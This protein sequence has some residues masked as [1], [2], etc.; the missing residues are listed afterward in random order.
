MTTQEMN[1]KARAA[2]FQMQFAVLMLNVGRME[3]ADKAFQK[4]EAA[5]TAV[6]EATGGE[7]GEAA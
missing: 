6:V 4:A 2:R 7:Q 1:K 3:E 5:M